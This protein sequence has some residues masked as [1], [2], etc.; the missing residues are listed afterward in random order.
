MWKN[1]GA[2]KVSVLHIYIDNNNNNN[3]NN[4][5]EKSLRGS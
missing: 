1:V 5:N 4:N 2:S 3:N